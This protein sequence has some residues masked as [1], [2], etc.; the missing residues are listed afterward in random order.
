MV[1]FFDSL[2]QGVTLCFFMWVLFISD[3]IMV[4]AKCKESNLATI[5]SKQKATGAIKSS[6]SSSKINEEKELYPYLGPLIPADKLSAR[7]PNKNYQV[8]ANLE[9][10][11]YECDLPV[12]YR[13]LRWGMLHDS[14]SFISQ[15]FY[16][17][18]MKYTKIKLGKKWNHSTNM[19]G[20]PTSSWKI[21]SGSNVACKENELLMPK[22]SLIPANMC[23]EKLFLLEHNDYCFCLR[24][25]AR[26]PGVPFGK[27]FV[28]WTQFLVIDNGNNSCR[29]ICS[30]EPEFIDENKLSS[31]IKRS[32]RNGMRAGTYDVFRTFGKTVQQ[33]AHVYPS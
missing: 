2:L 4:D 33:Y 16:E 9:Y 29:M 3:A 7:K 23:H 27:N 5:A 14:S 19:I 6:P 12:G 11:V 13:R 18:E 10:I 17:K 26:T 1:R 20:H 32:I 21:M 24:K 22:S 31:F 25:M 30:V 15:A 8:P 28:S